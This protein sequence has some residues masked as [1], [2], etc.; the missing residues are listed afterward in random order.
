MRTFHFATCEMR[1]V[2]SQ[3]PKLLNAL[4]QALDAA[5]AHHGE[6][7]VRDALKDWLP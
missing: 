3:G 4:Q 7:T 5:V 1:P 6:D 2:R